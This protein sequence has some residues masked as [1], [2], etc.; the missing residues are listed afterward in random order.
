MTKNMKTNSLALRAIVGFIPDCIV[1]FK[2]LVKDE[3]VPSRYKLTLILLVAYLVSPI[4]IIPDFI[5]VLGQLDDAAIVGLA[6]RYI[7]K[8]AG[9][10][11]L[12]KNWPG[13]QSSLNTLLK[14]ASVKS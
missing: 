6:L 4:D 2:N 14:L 9:P 10:E 8:G 5:P 13:P 1:L 7:L 11:L 12:A 3:E